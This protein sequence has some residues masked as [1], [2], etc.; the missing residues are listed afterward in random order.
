MQKRKKKKPKSHRSKCNKFSILR[1][2]YALKSVNY[3]QANQ[4]QN[5]SNKKKEKENTT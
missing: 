3:S 4:M 5:G 1:F 2:I